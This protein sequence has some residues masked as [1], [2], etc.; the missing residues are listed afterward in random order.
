[1]KNSE[2]KKKT[3]NKAKPEGTFAGHFFTKRKKST[4]LF[5]SIPGF[6]YNCNQ[7]KSRIVIEYRGY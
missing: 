3:K 5:F 4:V 7:N 6:L 1:M 2:R